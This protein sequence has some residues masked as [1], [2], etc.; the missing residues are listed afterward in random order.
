MFGAFLISICLFESVSTSGKKAGG[1]NNNKNAG[2]KG[3]VLKVIND[4]PLPNT[5]KKFAAVWIRDLQK[6]TRNAKN[7][8]KE[9]FEKALGLSKFVH[10]DDTHGKA[11]S[12]KIDPLPITRRNGEKKNADDEGTV[13]D[14]SNPPASAGKTAS[15]N[16]TTSID[17]NVENVSQKLKDLTL[18][19]DILYKIDNV[20]VKLTDLSLE[21]N[22]SDVPTPDNTLEADTNEENTSSQPDDPSSSEKSDDQM[23]DREVADFADHQT[24]WEQAVLPINLSQLSFLKRPVDLSPNSEYLVMFVD[25]PNAVEASKKMGGNLPTAYQNMLAF[26]MFVDRVSLGKSWADFVSFFPENS[27]FN[28]CIDSLLGSQS[29]LLCTACILQARS[30]RSY[31]CVSPF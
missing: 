19:E 24:P 27:L 18:A 26:S 22:R 10:E 13:P 20:T 31:T 9:M 8:G 7:L 16:G 4:M 21:D 15:E 6:G 30:M 2:G 14:T 11:V 12:A 23:T 28:A 3:K 25:A 17:T 29:E 5:V 1:K